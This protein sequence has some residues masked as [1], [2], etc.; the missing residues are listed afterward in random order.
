MDRVSEKTEPMNDRMAPLLEARNVS[1]VYSGSGGAFARQRI[2][3]A[4]SGADL[5]LSP[6]QTMGLVGESG[7]GKTSLGLAVMGL[8]P[9]SDGNVRFKGRDIATLSKKDL[10]A[11][12]ADMGLVFQDPASSLPPRMRIGS[13]IA[14]P[15]LVHK[16]GDGKDRRKKAEELMETVGLDKSLYG[17]YP[18]QLSGGQRQR[19]AIA[20]A[21]I[22]AP[23]LIVADEPV[24]SLDISIQVQV[25]ELFAKLRE[26]M[27]C[28]MIFI[29]HDIRVVRALTEI[30]CVMYLGYQVETGPTKTVLESPGH[31][32]TRLLIDSIPALHPDDRKSS[33]PAEQSA[34]RNPAEGCPFSPRCPH[35]DG[36]CVEAMPPWRDRDGRRIRCFHPLD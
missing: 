12:R 20:R 27:G 24:A 1:V 16:M 13:I 25:L 21:L 4:A 23:S 8:T 15:L 2:V 18:H 31:P 3:R 6:S 33:R 22:T 14:E 26:E 34:D 17:Y 30:C 32:Y 29:S 11:L 10:R 35:A 9:T 7:C 28:A 36:M 19:A 5:S